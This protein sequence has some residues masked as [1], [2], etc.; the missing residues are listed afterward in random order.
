MIIYLEVPYFSLMS[1][2]SNPHMIFSLMSGLSNTH[3][4]S[5][6]HSTH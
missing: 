3:M 1:G 2:L 4:N 5:Q 6:I